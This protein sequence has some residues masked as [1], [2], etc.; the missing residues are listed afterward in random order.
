MNSS[1]VGLPS[2]EGMRIR[3]RPRTSLRKRRSSFRTGHA[4]LHLP[5]GPARLRQGSCRRGGKHVGDQPKPHRRR[6][7]SL[8]A[9]SRSTSGRS[10]PGSKRWLH[11]VVMELGAVPA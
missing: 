6:G 1:T 2:R 3:S 5:S 8:S 9:G 4:Y 11:T 10:S 7:Q